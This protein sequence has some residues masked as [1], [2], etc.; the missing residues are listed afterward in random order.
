MLTLTLPEP[1]PGTLELGPCTPDALRN[2]S[3]IEVAKLPAHLGN[4]PVEWGDFLR[5]EGDAADGTV[6]LIGDCQRL[7]R[8]GAGMASGTLTVE[9]RAGWHAGAQMTGGELA[10]IGDAGDWLG[11]ELRGGTIRVTGDAGHLAGASYRGSRHGVRGGFIH[12]GGDA[13]DEL[14]LLMRRGTIAVAG[15]AGAFA[16]ASLI[17]G[18][19]VLA[20]GAGP[21]VGAGAKRGTLLIRGRPTDSPGYRPVGP[22]AP[23]YLK[24]LQ[25]W[26]TAEGFRGLTP[27]DV[28][29][30][31]EQW[32]GDFVH[33]GLA[34]LWALPV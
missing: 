33:R 24:L 1:P 30:A 13:G 21:H 16:G 11:A 4:R 2:L 19:L 20:G 6:R 8:V 3:A 17:A 22:S 15:K 29:G 34:E 25:R 23:A 28:A 27:G 31:L 9:G 32:R 18:T 14:G 10:V 12:I 7:P 5:V 26:L